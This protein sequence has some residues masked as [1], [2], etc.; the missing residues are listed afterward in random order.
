MTNF[1][2][3]TKN[4][5]SY[6]NTLLVILSFCLLCFAETGKT[7]ANPPTAAASQPAQAA[8]NGAAANNGAAYYNRAMIQLSALPVEIRKQLA[9]PIF[10][11]YA[12]ST[13]E[14]LDK[15]VSHVAFAGRH[16]IASA[17]QGTQQSECDFGISYS[18]QGQNATVPHAAL[19]LHLSRLMTIAGIDAQ[20]DGKNEESADLFF[21]CLEMGRHLTQQSTL[22]EAHVG[23]EI[24]ENACFSIAFWSIRSNDPAMVAN[25]VPRFKKFVAKSQLA[26]Q[27]TLQHEREHFGQQLDRVVAAYPDGNWAELILDAWGELTYGTSQ[28]ELES[29]LFAAAE[30]RG[31]PATT[32][33]DQSSFNQKANELRQ[34]QTDY[35]DACAECVTMKD[36][37]RA[38]QA[39]KVYA[40]FQPRFQAIGDANFLDIRH[41][42]GHYAA[43][44]AELIM[45]EVTM[46][47]ASRHADGKYPD[48]LND[49]ATVF[50]GT[51]PVSPYNGSALEYRT[52]NN[53]ADFLIAVPEVRHGGIAYPRIE[54]SSA[55]PAKPS[56][57]QSGKND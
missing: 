20:I 30:K 57:P 53:G 14:E 7:I 17:L 42:V 11:T 37:D 18:N 24:V 1:E 49:V 28:L 19:M 5:P 8:E 35:L 9:E 29:K 41:L 6:V 34:L 2:M 43:Y 23:M 26:M 39:G 36:P 55:R 50:N 25:H 44:Q 45:T 31:I 48:A 40:E 46:A 32:F 27:D 22:V 38:D 21:A 54:F 33:R 12:N 51:L 3:K 13:R 52:L 15:A 16:V 4:D 47:I 10:V 56:N